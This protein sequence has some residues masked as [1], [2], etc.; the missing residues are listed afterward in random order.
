MTEYQAL[1]AAAVTVTFYALL[2]NRV[3]RLVHSLRM[4]MAEMGEELLNTERLPGHIETHIEASLDNAYCTFCAWVAVFAL[5]FA[6]IAVVVD[7]VK[8]RPDPFAD[9]PHD[10]RAKVDQFAMF[11]FIST[12]A[13]SPLAALLF[14]AQFI[15][16]LVLWIPA[17]RLARELFS[18]RDV[19]ANL[20]HGSKLPWNH[21]HA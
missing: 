8:K 10:L 17:G 20:I 4:Q 16:L 9:V 14:A 6:A 12:L 18:L 2:C 1:L 3:T 21:N 15:V 19:L 7:R 11:S 5:P 13:N